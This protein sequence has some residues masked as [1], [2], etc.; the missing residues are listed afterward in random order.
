MSNFTQNANIM[1]QKSDA[2]IFRIEAVFFPPN[3][4]PANRD[5]CA[6][7]MSRPTPKATSTIM[8]DQLI[9]RV[10]RFWALFNK[11]DINYK[12]ILNSTYGKVSPVSWPGYVAAAVP[13]QIRHNICTGCSRCRR[14]MGPG[15]E[16]SLRSCTYWWRHSTA[17]VIDWQIDK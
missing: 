17:T 5:D 2:F 14:K 4:S 16:M 8:A 1:L 11:W 15:W 3:L 6:G 9:V 7:Q 12:T 10:S 13:S